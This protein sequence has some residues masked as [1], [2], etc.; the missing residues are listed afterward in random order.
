VLHK[1]VEAKPMGKQ[2]MIDRDDRERAIEVL[3]ETYPKAFFANPKLRR[4]LK[5]DIVKDIKADLAEHPDSELKFY[6]IDDAVDWYRSHVGYHHACAVA[7]TPR[8]NLKGERAATVTAGEA[9]EEGEIAQQIFDE[10]EARKRKYAYVA[11]SNGG[12]VASPALK[13]LKVDT[14]LNDDELLASI[15]QHVVTLK[16][17]TG[18]PDPKVQKELSRSVVL[19]LIDELK[20][21]DARLTK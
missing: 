1:H 5:H 15:A 2:P 20:T 12:Y 14:T 4:P 13:T 21:L 19:L 9:R 10:I 16:T 8:I 3:C 11:P 18:L 6:D 17:L 7:G